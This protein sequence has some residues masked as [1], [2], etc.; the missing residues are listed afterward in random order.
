MPIKIVAG[1]HKYGYGILVDP[2]KVK[3][4]SDLEKPDIRIGC[5]R[6]G[7]V[8]DVLLHKTIDKY[9]LDKDRILK[10]VRRMPPPKILLALKTGQLDVAFLPE[11]FPTMGE[12]LGFKELLSAR[13]LWPEM[14]GSVLIV[15]EELIRDNPEIVK[16]LV[17]VTRRGINY[18]NKHPKDAADIVANELTVTGEKISPLEVAKIASKLEITPE[19]ILKSLTTKMEC[20]AD[21]DP[22]MVQEEINY[23]AELGYIKRFNALDIVDVKFNESK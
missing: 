16:K 15:R 6:E 3:N 23:L 2:N 10:K 18:I 9:Q 13:D 12:E 11:Q 5:P 14:Q 7:S 19:V 8:L 22:E 21:L 17:E 20:T 1:T 4:V